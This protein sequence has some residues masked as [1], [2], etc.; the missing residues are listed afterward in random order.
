VDYSEYNQKGANGEG[1]LPSLHETRQAIIN[2]YQEVLDI[3]AR[4]FSAF[5]EDTME[6]PYAIHVFGFGDMSTKDKSVFPFFLSRNLTSRP[7]K[8]TEEV[9][10]RYVETTRNIILSQPTSFAPLIRES[11]KLVNET[12]S[13]HTLV[14]LS[15]G[16]IDNIDDTKHALQEASKVSLSII[17]IGVGEG[18]FSQML[19]LYETPGR[20]FE[21]Y[22]FISV[23]HVFNVEKGNAK[24]E[25]AL[26]CNI[27]QEIP[28]HHAAIKKLGYPK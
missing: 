8:G 28:A 14:I 18:S 27:L 25:V 10:K 23:H 11:I 7:C 12:S 19:E 16:Q 6:E 26:A 17:V 9:Q 4:T 22:H 15:P 24:R 20:A 5:G 21:N 2:P 13:Y 1:I 3:V